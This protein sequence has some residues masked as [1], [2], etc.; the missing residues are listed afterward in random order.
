MHYLLQLVKFG[1]T[2]A[3]YSLI[4]KG[5][6]PYAVPYLTK[7]AERSAS[8]AGKRGLK[9]KNTENRTTIRTSIAQQMHHVPYVVSIVNIGSDMALYA[10]TASNTLNQSYNID[11]ASESFQS[12][13]GPCKN[14]VRLYGTA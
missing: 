7:Q 10:K 1:L 13:N 6:P 4:I 11:S 12:P 3:S 2:W 9:W 14:L 5:K 8:D